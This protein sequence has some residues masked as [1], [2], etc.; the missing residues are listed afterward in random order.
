MEQARIRRSLT[1]RFYSSGSCCLVTGAKATVLS[2]FA[3]C[4]TRGTGPSEIIRDPQKDVDVQS[5]V[6]P[7]NRPEQSQ[8]TECEH[9]R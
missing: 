4:G 7:E 6:H 9:R 3:E 8:Q 5:E 2:T 1:P